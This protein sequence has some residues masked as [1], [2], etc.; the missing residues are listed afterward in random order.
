MFAFR[1]ELGDYFERAVA[2]DGDGADPA[3]IANWIPPLVE[4]IGSDADPA[5]S[6]VPPES[7]AALAAMVKSQADQPR[8]RARAADA[9]RR[10]RR[11]PARDRRAREPRRDQRWA[12]RDRRPR[13]RG[14]SRGGREGPRRQPEGDRPARRL[15]DARGEG[16]SGRGRGQAVDS[17]AARRRDRGRLRRRPWGRA[18]PSGPLTARSGRSGRQS[19]SM[20]LSSLLRAAVI[21]LQ[22]YV[23][24]P[25]K[26]GMDPLVMILIAV[27]LYLGLLVFVLALCK[28]AAQGDDAQ[29][30]LYGVWARERQRSGRWARPAQRRRAAL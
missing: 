2:S 22:S 11:R 18:A 17:G 7:L 15:R 1:A 8:H 13:D 29:R 9:I 12:G 24:E 20:L 27:A 5:D 30:D 14:R 23:G 26:L 3:T 4:R 6:K 25:M 16:P 21:A 28:M 19:A 10:R